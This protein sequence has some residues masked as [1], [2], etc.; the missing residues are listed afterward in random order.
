ME[1]R[2]RE[3]R[4]CGVSSCASFGTHGAR[5]L[6]T[7]RA[8]RLGRPSEPRGLGGVFGGCPVGARRPFEARGLWGFG[9]Y[10]YYY[11]F[12]KI[13]FLAIDS[14]C[15]DLQIFTIIIIITTI[16]IIIMCFIIIITLLYFSL[17][18]R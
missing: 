6:R 13:R 11:Y 5:R 18:R 7:A 16:I 1:S 9:G 14:T 15:L 10:Y 3:S 12:H 4:F 8:V 2:R 17:R